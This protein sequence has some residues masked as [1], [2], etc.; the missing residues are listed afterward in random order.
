M[1]Q[2]THLRVG[3]FLVIS[4]CSFALKNSCASAQPAQIILLGLKYFLQFSFNCS[5]SALEKHLMFSNL[6]TEKRMLLNKG[7]VPYIQTL[8]YGYTAVFLC[9]STTKY[10]N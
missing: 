6:N 5:P 8:L 9:F 7:N 2:T 1:C 10:N 4:S 3:T